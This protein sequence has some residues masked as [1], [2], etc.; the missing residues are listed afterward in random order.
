V[1]NVLTKRELDRQANPDKV[2]ASL[3]DWGVKHRLAASLGMKRVEFTGKQLEKLGIPFAQVKYGP[4]IYPFPM[5]KL[6]SSERRPKQKE[7]VNST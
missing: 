2:G 7:S 1:W 4:T 3:M 6:K 5:A